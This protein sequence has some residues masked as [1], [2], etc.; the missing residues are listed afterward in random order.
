[1]T[2]ERDGKSRRP[3]QPNLLA[4]LPDERPG[5]GIDPTAI[6]EVLTSVQDLREQF[7][8]LREAVSAER[9]AP[10]TP[11]ALEAWGDKLV[12]R[13]AEAAPGDNA[14]AG[15]EAV[16]G[17][18]SDDGI[19]HR[20]LRRWGRARSRVHEERRGRSLG[21][22]GSD[23]PRPL[24]V[25]PGRAAG[26]PGGRA[27][28]AEWQSRSRR[29]RR[30]VLLRRTG[31]GRRVRWPSTRQ[32]PATITHR[33]ASRAAWPPPRNTPCRAPLARP[34]RAS[35]GAW[36]LGSSVVRRGN[37][38]PAG[39]ATDRGPGSAGPNSDADR[40]MGQAR[41]ARNARRARNSAAPGVEDGYG[42]PGSG[43]R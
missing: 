28:P 41:P 7:A 12:A 39:M 10:V 13:I 24:S 9:P 36:S 23:R 14:A 27:R 34:R 43:M 3:A 33:A 26:G 40:R 21:R 31:R 37:C 4:R 29:P 5:P 19:G 15:L 11:E 17:D 30:R 35:L 1:M 6:E 42:S 8:G 22:P 32:G 20:V 38:G 16:E 2:A 25:S 18:G